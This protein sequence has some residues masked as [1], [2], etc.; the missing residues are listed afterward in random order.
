MVRDSRKAIGEEGF[1][2]GADFIEAEIR[3]RIRNMIEGIVA[4]ELEA[5]LGAGKSQRVGAARS[6]Y[7]HGSRERQLTTSLG[8]TTILMPRA[9]LQD[10]A[11]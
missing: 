9:R 2:W 8:P 11:G 1:E 4:E 5:A 10:E 6:G 7:R 3:S